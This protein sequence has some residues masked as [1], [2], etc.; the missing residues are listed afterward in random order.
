MDILVFADVSQASSACADELAAALADPAVRT[1]VVAG[2]NSPRALYRL[3]AQR[4]LAL[5]HLHVFTLDEYLGVPDHDRRICANLLRQEVANAW[6][7]PDPRFHFLTSDAA[8]APAAVQK[9]E[10]ELEELGGIDVAVVGLGRNGHLGFNEPPSDAESPSRVL[11]LSPTSV[12]A[13]ATWFSGQYA[14][15][16][17][18]TLGLK[19]ILSARRILMLAF[20]A[21][22]SEAVCAMVSRPPSPSCPASFLQRHSSVRVFLD[23]ASAAGLPADACQRMV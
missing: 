20:G 3:I 8:V 5:D 17:G 22:K 23:S 11:D 15:H 18:V 6:R 16:Q 13:N 14:P 19:R 1:L 7:V 9:H 12:E 2:G 4:R 10:R 21:A